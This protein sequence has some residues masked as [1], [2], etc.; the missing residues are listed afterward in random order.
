MA[1]NVDM[2]TWFAIRRIQEILAT[3]VLLQPRHP[4]QQS[5]FIEIVVR[6]HELLQKANSIKRRISFTDDVRLFPQVTDITDAVRECRD[7]VCHV[8][9]NG[10][11]IAPDG[12]PKQRGQR[13]PQGQRFFK[14][15]FNVGYGKANLLHTPQFTIESEYEDDVCFF[16]GAHRLYLKRHI[17]RAVQEAAVALAPEGPPQRPTPRQ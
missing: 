13:L 17:I 6:L 9:A 8:H 3:N 16:Y 7:A 14:M 2:D 12:S 15:T 1:T 11:F 10:H 4:L 5:A